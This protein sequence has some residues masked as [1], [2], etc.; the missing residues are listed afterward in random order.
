M[1]VELKNRPNATFGFTPV[2]SI[3]PSFGLGWGP[4]SIRGEGW[5]FDVGDGDK[6]SHTA[7]AL[8]LTV[9]LTF[10]ST[11]VGTLEYFHN[12]KSLGVAFNDIRGTVRPAI[13]FGGSATGTATLCAYRG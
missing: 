7:G 1:R 10:A 11:G 4:A 12:G 2:G 3:N 13:C 5:G 6:V 9:W 8:T